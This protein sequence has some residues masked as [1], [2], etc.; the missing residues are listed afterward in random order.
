MKVFKRIIWIILITALA[1]CFYFAYV[2]YYKIYG[3]NVKIPTHEKEA[4]FFIKTGSDFRQVYLDLSL[5]GF[6][7]DTASFRWLAKQ[8]NYP[9]HI[10][11]GKYEVKRGMSNRSLILK[12]R[13]GSQI[14]VNLTINL[15]K[16][17]EELAGL[18]GSKLEADSTR[19]VEK[20]NNPE[21]LSRFGLTPEKSLTLIIPNT[22]EFYWNTSSSEFLERMGKEY[23]NF[24]NETRKHKAEQLDLQPSEV[25]ILA[26]IVQEESSVKKEWPI[27]AGVYIN[28][29]K[30][31]WK[32]QADPTL[33]FIIKDRK[34]KRIYDKDLEIES[35]YN[36]YKYEGLPPGP[37]GIA[38]IDAIDAVLNFENHDYMYFC[39]KAD[40]SGHHHFSKTLSA[41]LK[42]AREYQE[43]LNRKKIR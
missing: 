34:V 15:V 21:F 40:F 4:Y 10:Y 23:E 13:S 1:C 31:N 9:S 43:A 14:P 39:A 30:R 12:F 26:T 20:L 16:T 27:I 19:I 42:Y 6:L 28:R 17:K 25:A 32:L 11:P 5:N 36:T 7:K 29:L 41:H 35:P 38:E 37:I 18:V 2:Y 8:M 3:P 22:Y 33:K 24:W